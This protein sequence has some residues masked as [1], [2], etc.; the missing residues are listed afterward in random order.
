MDRVAS[1]QSAPIHT[2]HLNTNA[3]QGEVMCGAAQGQSAPTNA[4]EVS[5]SEIW[6]QMLNIG[7]IGVHDTFLRLGGE[8]LAATE[9]A[10]MIE[11]RH[12]CKISLRSIL[13]NTVRE[14]AAEIIATLELKATETVK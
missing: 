3:P 6:A 4:V 1:A 7:G 5:V 13:V 10:A 12:G 11:E 9:A 14:V 8:S 2:S